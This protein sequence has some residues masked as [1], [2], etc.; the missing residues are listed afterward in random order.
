MQYFKVKIRGSGFNKERWI[1]VS[2]KNL[3]EAM[4]KA[5]ERCASFLDI[6]YPLEETIWGGPV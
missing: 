3:Y 2:A 4:L 6:F 5:H 1:V